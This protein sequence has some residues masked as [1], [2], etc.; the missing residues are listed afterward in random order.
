[1]KFRVERDTISDVVAWV[2]RAL[3]PRPQLPTLAGLRLEVAGDRL[4][5]CGF[6]YEVST[7]ATL[8]VAAAEE[9]VALVSGRLLADIVRSLPAAPV[10]LVAEATRVVLT[11]GSSRFVL[12]TLPLEE[13]PALPE[14]PAVSGVAG[15][16]EFASAV[17][18][19]AVA[20]GRDD[21]LPALTGIRL[22][23]D[24]EHLTLAATDRYRLAVRTLTWQ[25]QDPRLSTAALVP[26]RTLADTA[27][28][29]TSAAQVSVA[30]SSGEAGD[31]IIGFFGADRRTT[32]RLLGGEFPRYRAL[33]P[34]STAAT[35]L[36]ETAALSESVKRVALVAARN[37]PVRL[38]FGGDERVALEAG[39]ADEAQASESVPAAFEGEPLTI[40]FNPTYLLDGLA[41]LNSDTARLAFTAAT[42]PAVLTGKDPGGQDADY[43]YL[44]MPVRL[45]E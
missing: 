27:R 2:A 22:E 34:S 13:Y 32:T 29:L 40:A 33:L 28:A 26:A 15:S 5:V 9:G 41:A 35:A 10:E 3:P 21:T 14:M 11:C 1:M 23:V 43:R 18:S 4:R 7:E 37:A 24:G 20:A 31:G 39:G 17:A 45:T 16:D 6:D 38:T 36:L 44:L 8:G 12:P 42:K 19:V 30:L 25:P